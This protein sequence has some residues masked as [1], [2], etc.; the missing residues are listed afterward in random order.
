[1]TQVRPK[2]ALSLVGALLA[3]WVAI[4]LSLG[5]ANGDPT[6]LL[7]P[8]V[9]DTLKITYLV[10]LYA[11]LMTATA[12][13]WRRF[14]PTNLCIGRFSDLLG[15]LTLGWSL[16][17]LHR[18]TLWICG[19]WHPSSPFPWS[20]LLLAFLTSPLIA[21][22]EELVFR[23][24]LYGNLRTTAGKVLVSL[25]FALLHLFRPG[26]LIFKLSLGFGLFL[27]S[28][29]LMKCLDQRNRLLYPTGLHASWVVAAVVDPPQ[30]L[31]S[32]WFG[33]LRGE[34]MAGLLAWL[35]LMVIILWPKANCPPKPEDFKKE[36]TQPS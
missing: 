30:N 11:W 35:L 4:W 14:A 8:G 24:Y 1:L 36:G 5:L 3:G 16:L 19:Q 34:P 29:A 10:L 28:L 25:F 18:G 6:L 17:I 26:D 20:L 21:F 9:G 33:G 32:G 31:Q 2:A 13:C 27:V 12:L 15:G 23:G 22:S 7:R